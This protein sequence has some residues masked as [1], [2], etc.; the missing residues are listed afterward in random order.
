M[1]P[2]DFGEPVII[3]FGKT[4]DNLTVAHHVTHKTNN[5][6]ITECFKKV[7]ETDTILH[8]RIRNDT[9]IELWIQHIVQHVPGFLLLPIITVKNPH[10]HEDR[11]EKARKSSPSLDAFMQAS[12]LE[13]KTITIALDILTKI[14]HLCVGEGYLVQRDILKSMLQHPHPYQKWPQ[15]E[16][17]SFLSNR[18]AP[19]IH[20]VCCEYIKKHKK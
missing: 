5:R 16:K 18:F 2:E 17:L 3:K 20:E 14:P 15:E 9:A 11:L 10:E 4:P 1:F 7:L 6:P 19:F 12:Q 13:Y 8:G